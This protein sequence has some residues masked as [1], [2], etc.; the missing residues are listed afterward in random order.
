VLSECGRLGPEHLADTVL[1]RLGVS[2]GGRD[3]IA[4]IVVRL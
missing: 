2:S 3:D 1:A 4:V